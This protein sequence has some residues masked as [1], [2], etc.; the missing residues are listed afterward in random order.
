MGVIK[1]I[2]P[3]A[4]LHQRPF[5]KHKMMSRLGLISQCISDAVPT[6]PEEVEFLST[7]LCHGGWRWK[8][9]PHSGNSITWSSQYHLSFHTWPHMFSVPRNAR[10]PGS[11]LR[12]A[13][14]VLCSLQARKTDLQVQWR[15]TKNFDYYWPS[16]WIWTTTE[17]PL[18][19]YLQTT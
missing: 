17:I 6:F 12:H 10:A 4:P 18:L 8:M 2:N 7:Y 5:W 9:F 1:S 13:S 3:F 11:V 16:R 19:G 15:I 14:T